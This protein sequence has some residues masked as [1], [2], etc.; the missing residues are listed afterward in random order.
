MATWRS[1]ISHRDLQASHRD[2]QAYH[3]DLQASHRDLQASHRDLQVFYM[4]SWAW[5]WQ[6]TCAFRILAAIAMCKLVS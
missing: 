2:L 4:K 3:R 1:F 5:S 6:Q